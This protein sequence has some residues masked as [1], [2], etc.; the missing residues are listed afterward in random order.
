MQELAELFPRSEKHTP[1]LVGTSEEPWLTRDAVNILKSIYSPFGRLLEFGC[2][3]STLWWCKWM[4]PRFTSIEHDEEWYNKTKEALRLRCSLQKVNLLHIPDFDI[5]TTY[6][7]NL[8]NE[9]DIVVVD[10]RKRVKCIK[11]SWGAVRV[12]G[13]LVLD[14]SDREYYQEGIDYML[15]DNPGVIDTWNG[16]F[17]TSFYRKIK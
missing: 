13:Y 11:N 3:S 15:A 10:G 16:L 17:R 9:F 2:G 4:K 14:N 6:L 12:G 8:I 5:Y 7:S 1:D